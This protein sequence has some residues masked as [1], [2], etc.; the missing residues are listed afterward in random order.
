MDGMF[1]TGNGVVSNGAQRAAGVGI[2]RH[3]FTSIT[4][5]VAAVGNQQRVSDNHSHDNHIEEVINNNEHPG[6]P[7]I[8]GRL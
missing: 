2:K 7:V 4:S 3:A 8:T 6:F 1:W 5:T